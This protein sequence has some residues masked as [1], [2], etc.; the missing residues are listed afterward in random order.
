MSNIITALSV[1]DV[2]LIGGALKAIVNGFWKGIYGIYFAIVKAIAWVLDML[3]QLFFIF[4]GMTPVS[5]TAASEA[6]GEYAKI[7]IVNFFLTQSSF[8]KAYLYLCLVAL[9]L[10]IVFAIGKIIKQDYFDR[11]GPRS[12]GPIFRNIALS[13]IAFIC[14]IPVFYF[15][16]DIVAALA[17]LVMQAMGYKG[18]GIGSLVFNISW[19]DNGESI[20]TVGRLIGTGSVGPVEIVEGGLTV[21]FTDDMKESSIYDADNFGW[22]SGDTFYAYYWNSN[23]VKANVGTVEF[24]WYI[25]IFTGLILIVNLGQMMLAMVTRMYNL[26]ALF[27]VAPSPISQ[28]VL[29]DGAKFKGWKDKVLQESLKVVGCVM[30]FMLFIMII[31]VVNTLDLMKYA[32]T[33]ESASSLSLLEDNNL[34][35]QLSNVS[36]LYY[37][38]DQASW[39]DKAVNA[40]GRCMII[41]AG[42]GAI[43]DIDSTITPFISGGSSSMDMGNAGKALVDAG[44][45]AVNGA[46]A[47]GRAGVGLAVKGATAAVSLAAGA[48]GEAAQGIEAGIGAG[49]SIAGGASEAMNAANTS[50]PKPTGPGEGGGAS[51]P[52]PAEEKPENDGAGAAEVN[53]TPNA[54]QDGEQQEEAVDPNATQGGEQQEEAV[55]P[56]ATQGGEQQEEAVD[57]NA[58]Q[59]GEQQEE[60]VDP[61][62]TQGGEQQEEAVDPNATQGGEHQG[63]EQQGGAAQA[64]T[65]GTEASTTGTKTENNNDAQVRFNS[66]HSNG[67]LGAGAKFARKAFAWGGGITTGATKTALGIT[68]HTLKTGGKL[69]LTGAR[70]GFKVAGILAKTVMQM[71]GMGKLAK[72]ADENFKGM[73][74]ELAD[75]GRDM[76]KAVRQ[77]APKYANAAK[78]AANVAKKVG[79]K[80]AST[81]VGQAFTKAG[82]YVSNSG[83]ILGAGFAGLAD[84]VDALSKR[85]NRMSEEDKQNMEQLGATSKTAS[86]NISVIESSKSSDMQVSQAADNTVQA[87]DQLLGDAGKTSD[88]HETITGERDSELDS[89]VDLTS[90]DQRADA[91]NQ[92]IETAGK[93]QTSVDGFMASDV[94]VDSKTEKRRTARKHNVARNEHGAIESIARKHGI[95]A[96]S[97]GLRTQYSDSISAVESYVADQALAEDKRTG[98]SAP[99]AAQTK[100]YAE[101]MAKAQ[102]LDGAYMHVSGYGGAQS[103]AA[104]ESVRAGIEATDAYKEVMDLQ[105]VEKR[106]VTGKKGRGEV[107]F[108]E[109]LESRTEKLEDSYES[110]MQARSAAGVYAANTN[111]DAVQQEINDA[112]DQSTSVDR[113]KYHQA[114]FTAARDRYEAVKKDK[115]ATADQIADARFDLHAEG[116]DLR[117]ASNAVSSRISSTKKTVV[118]ESKNNADRNKGQVRYDR[119]RDTIKTNIQTM[120]DNGASDAEIQEVQDRMDSLHATATDGGAANAYQNRTRKKVTVTATAEMEKLAKSTTKRVTKKGAT[121]PGYTPKTPTPT[122]TSGTDYDVT[123][124]VDMKNKAAVSKAVSEGVASKQFSDI[125]AAYA[126]AGAKDVAADNKFI[127]SVQAFDETALVNEGFENAL[128]GI[129]S[130]DIPDTY[131]GLTV[132]EYRK[133]VKARY[134]NAVNSYNANMS[135]AKALADEYAAS[136]EPAKLD[137]V[138]SAIAAAVRDSEAIR[139]V[140]AEIN[141]K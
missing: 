68:K 42:V 39:V 63:G 109:R 52:K 81:K 25:F 141:D 131:K 48:G 23:E 12:K 124:K 74:K 2:P 95:A 78:G 40:L 129:K 133:D 37:G 88:I 105:N 98:V 11:N 21:F 45:A 32:Y 43:K 51:A 62:A 70:T 83:G 77:Q 104:Y 28:I 17:L 106:K 69:A 126:G 53:N 61:N 119:A 138:R 19:E 15:L 94:R 73:G 71:T 9:G 13:F 41:L 55:D 50:A 79:N 96:M 136:G 112:W 47:I 60:A 16:I 31:S 115:T 122:Y 121:A 58:T 76:V 127:A 34:T 140:K 108:D 35:T 89:K 132:P 66:M 36:A 20:K 134:E 107:A 38:G 49:K 29:D 123:V 80:I 92:S 59:G 117:R 1:Y 18:G 85:K 30:S 54:T 8:Q 135:K 6:S 99:T 90:M 93:H 65:D 110:G 125:V 103:K 64:P 128:K 67:K 100:Q 114:R 75:G 97:D 120:R 4:A 27:I 86:E 116:L 24:Y 118:S 72:M 101:Y 3:T 139:I 5:S 102:E 22:Y 14:I 113:L 44:S 84:G 46:M 7:D 56:N 33:E 10:I 111:A 26:I 87:V 57:P 91:A 137:A 130:A 82:E